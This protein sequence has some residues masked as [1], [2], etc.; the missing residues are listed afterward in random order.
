MQRRCADLGE[1]LLAFG[2]VLFGEIARVATEAF[3]TLGDEV[4]TPTLDFTEC[5]PLETGG[6]GGSG[7]ATD[8]IERDGGFAFGRPVLDV[9]IGSGVFVGWRRGRGLMAAPFL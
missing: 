6:L 2:F 3:G 9:W 5:K 8:E 4:F 7:F 1:E